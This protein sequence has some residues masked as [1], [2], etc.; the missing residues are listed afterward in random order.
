MNA[1]S[2]QTTSYKYKEPAQRVTTNTATKETAS[3]QATVDTKQFTPFSA[4][5][6]PRTVYSVSSQNIIITEI[7]TKVNSS[8]NNYIRKKNMK[9]PR[10]EEDYTSYFPNMAIETA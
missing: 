4:T 1:T 2:K 3:N 5:A 8:I 7:H 9:A 10:I 6:Q